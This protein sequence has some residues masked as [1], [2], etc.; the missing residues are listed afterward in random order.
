V[1][2]EFKVN[3]ITSFIS[4]TL[5]TLHPTQDRKQKR[6][7]VDLPDSFLACQVCDKP[8]VPRAQTIQLTLHPDRIAFTS[9]QFIWINQINDKIKMLIQQLEVNEND[10]GQDFQKIDQKIDE[11]QIQVE[12]ARQEAYAKNVEVILSGQLTHDLDRL[13]MFEIVEIIPPR[14]VDEIPETIELVQQKLR[15]STDMNPRSESPM[16]IMEMRTLTIPS[17]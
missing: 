2:A 9:S 17:F 13:K 7:K 3:E 16:D 14:T 15:E 8:Q 4:Q 5:T 1:L 6:R 10:V 12:Q 11:L